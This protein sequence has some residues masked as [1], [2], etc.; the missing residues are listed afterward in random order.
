MEIHD[1][2]VPAT[3][4]NIKSGSQ[5][6]LRDPVCGMQVE[7]AS[8][9]HFQRHDSESY[10]FCSVR[11]EEKFLAEPDGYIAGHAA[12]EPMPKGTQYTC[13]MHPE[14][15][16]DAPGNC[17]KCGMALEPMG[18]PAG[19]NEPNPELIDFT[20]RLWIS[21]LC[22]APLFIL[23]MGP[24]LGLPFR[25]WLG[26]RLATWIE[27]A[28]ATPVVLWAAVPFFRRAWQSILNRSP[29]MW[30]LIGMGV[31]AATDSVSLSRFSRTVSGLVSYR[32]RSGTSLFRGR[33][34][35]CRTGVSRPGAGAA[36][37]RTNRL[38]HSGIDGS[39]SQDG[40]SGHGSGR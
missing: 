4:E 37:Q 33:R 31:G 26:D 8:A 1:H 6:V 35:Y 34:G 23:A 36:C 18:V 2:T 5:P 38:C 7:R 20:R 14:I 39:G 29:N 30:T 24:M 15:I 13:P 12:P 25:E 21:A 28:L 16:T 27:L 10:Y 3:V 11:C 22:A 17:P 19:D 40:S 9:A 32:W